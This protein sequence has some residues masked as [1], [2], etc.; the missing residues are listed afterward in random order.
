MPGRTVV[1]GASLAGLRAAES[2][3]RGGYDGRL[4][5]LGAERHR[6][7]DRPPLSKQILTGKAGP[8]ALPLRMD[9]DLD[10]DWQLGVQATH[11]DLDRRRVE[12]AGGD[13]VPF[14]RLVIATGAHPRTL[15]GAEP[16]QGV[17]YLRTVED[18]IAL[19]AELQ[20]A[21]AA[22]VVGAGFIG[23]EVAASARQLNLNVTVIEALPVPLE[24]AIGADMGAAIAGLHRR[25][26]VDVRLGVGVEGVVRSSRLEGVRLADGEVIPAEVVVV[27]IGVTPTTAWLDRSGVDLSDGVLCD[28]RLR[29]L[30]G[31]QPRPDVVA[32]GDVARWTHP[33]YGRTV[34]IEH[35]TNATEQGEAAARTLLAGENAPAY[36]PTPYFWSDQFGLKIQ[37]VGETLPGDDLAV[38]EGDPA[39]ERFL[40]A[41]GRD[42]RL[43][44]ALGMRRPARV[45]ALQ[46]LIGAGA[47]FPLEG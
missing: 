28:E 24:R 39:D 46:S 1:V 14:D 42:G 36:A 15:L 5:V 20:G 34:R 2:L 16:G 17:H 30:V 8:E 44:A 10:L 25:H 3:R 4:T 22:V 9:D 33:G 29:V 19:R 31:G 35:W 23:L 43:V 7:Y 27:G 18:A 47:P 6:P 45:M 26:G 13:D 41:Y 38:V 11:L 40:A 32:A 12:V 21:T 37:F